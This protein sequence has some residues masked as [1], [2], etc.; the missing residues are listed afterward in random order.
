MD[1]HE[2]INKIYDHEKESKP[3][4]YRT[5]KTIGDI[6]WSEFSGMPEL[7]EYVEV[8]YNEIDYGHTFTMHVDE[9]IQLWLLQKGNLTE[10]EEMVLAY[11]TKHV[12]DRE[13]A[14][15]EAGEDL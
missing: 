9:A 1:I 11:V 12:E 6:P 5:I 13:K 15:R 4:L 14:E 10:Q 2:A 7:H 8:T 3:K